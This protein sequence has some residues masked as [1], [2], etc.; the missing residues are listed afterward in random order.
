MFD[1]H[2]PVFALWKIRVNSMLSNV[3]HFL[4]VSLSKQNYVGDHMY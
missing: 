1:I 3:D 4:A 2:M